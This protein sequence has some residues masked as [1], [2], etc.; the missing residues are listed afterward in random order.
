MNIHPNIVIGA[1]LVA[2]IAGIFICDRISSRAAANAVI[3]FGVL[4]GS[5][6]L[7]ALLRP[8]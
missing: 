5:L 6:A 8:F 7:I 2:S 4:W 3:G 1:L